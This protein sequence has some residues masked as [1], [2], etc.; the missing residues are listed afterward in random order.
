MQN[1]KAA[2]TRLGHGRQVSFIINPRT[3]KSE[4]V[5]WMK[6]RVDGIKGKRIYAERL[7]VVEPVFGH[8][9]ANKGLDRFSLRGKDK[10]NGQWHLFSLVQNIEKMSHC[11]N[12]S[13]KASRR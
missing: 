8:I 2:D 3:Q 13:Q 10:V 9:R 11:M 1:P 6:K 7:A 12:E 4:P 5:E